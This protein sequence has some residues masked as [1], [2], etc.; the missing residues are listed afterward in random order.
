MSTYSPITIDESLIQEIKELVKQENHPALEK[1]IDES[2]PADL[3][4]LIEYLA[5]DE[6]L[7]ILALLK[8]EGA[9]EVLVEI[10]APVQESILDDLGPDHTEFGLHRCRR[11]HCT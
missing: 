4:D 3:A 2:L 7:F 11:T 6:R 8:P 5:P 10:E 9:G 1:L